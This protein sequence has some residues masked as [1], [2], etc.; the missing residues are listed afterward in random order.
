MLKATWSKGKQKASYTFHFKTKGIHEYEMA[1][2]PQDVK[3]QGG[4]NSIAKPMPKGEGKT[5]KVGMT[6][7]M[8]KEMA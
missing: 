7:S 1:K 5:K 6:S 4:L 8:P 2:G 3:H